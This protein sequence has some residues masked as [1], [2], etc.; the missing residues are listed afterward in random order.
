MSKSHLAEDWDSRYPQRLI[1]EM[2]AGTISPRDRGSLIEIL[3]GSKRARAQYIHYFQLSSM[4]H[5]E[6]V[7]LDSEGALPEIMQEDTQRKRFQYSLVASLAAV[8][9]IALTLGLVV[10][11]KEEFLAAMFQERETVDLESVEGSKWVVEN[12][13]GEQTLQGL[14]LEEG[15][16]V[17]VESGLV[18]FS[19]EPDVQFLL[20]GPAEV[21]F[22]ELRRPFLKKGWLWADITGDRQTVRVHTSDYEFIDIGT[23]FGIHVD[24]E[25]GVEL[26]VVDGQVDVHSKRKKK[27]VRT[28]S[29]GEA[30]IV[31]SGLWSEKV[32]HRDDPF[33]GA[34]ELLKAPASYRTTG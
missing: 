29:G 18:A 20:Q 19:L 15:Q 3:R 7:L 25:N 32:L 22:D 10:V 23:R 4:L 12:R 13:H 17:I 34:R 30:G 31:L 8:L 9:L 16:T 27:V 11:N 2:E 33:P 5:F 21:R 26:H 14:S 24:L 28:V 1:G 6:A